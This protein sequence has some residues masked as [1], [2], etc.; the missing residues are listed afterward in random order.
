MVQLYFLFMPFRLHHISKQNN[1][2]I[3]FHT[4]LTVTGLG[5]NL[6]WSTE[7][8]TSCNTIHNTGTSGVLELHHMDIGY[9]LPN[10]C[11]HSIIAPGWRFIMGYSSSAYKCN[12]LFI[13]NYK[14][15][16]NFTFF[17]FG[18]RTETS[19]LGYVFFC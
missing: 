16:L 1:L 18:E 3:I 13:V 4:D 15:L 12:Y 17:D 7:E 11:T 5:F 8:V 6:S 9:N 19:S 10:N 2:E 14:V